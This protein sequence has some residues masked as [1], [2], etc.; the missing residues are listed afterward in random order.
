MSSLIEPKH[1]FLTNLFSSSLEAKPI[2][3]LVFSVRFISPEPEKA[4]DDQKDG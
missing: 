2:P 4:D 1:S 3:R